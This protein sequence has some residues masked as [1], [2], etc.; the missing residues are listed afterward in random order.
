[1]KIA[2]FHVGLAL[3]GNAADRVSV[4]RN[5]ILVIACVRIVLFANK[6]FIFFSIVLL[7]NIRIIQLTIISYVYFRLN[8][9]S[10]LLG[11]HIIK[12]S[13]VTLGMCENF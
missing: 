1:M 10:V 11:I 9:I 4:H 8:F 12:C 13:L 6:F 2:F 5:V 7:I 3:F